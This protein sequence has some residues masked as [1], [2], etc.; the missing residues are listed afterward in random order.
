MDELLR[1]FVLSETV[2]FRRCEEAVHGNDVNLIIH[3][4]S[5]F[6]SMDSHCDNDNPMC[7]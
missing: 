2:Q 7:R 3:Y 5:F 4:T 1:K 6:L